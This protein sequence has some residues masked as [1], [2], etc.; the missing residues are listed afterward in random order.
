VGFEN[1]RRLITEDPLF[2]KSLRNTV[3]YTLMSVPFGL[4]TA[5]GLALLLNWEF[6]GRS[7]FRTLFF[8]PSVIPLVAASVLW[9]WLY[10]GEYGLINHMLG[11]VGIRGLNWM[12]DEH[13][14]KPAIVLM[15]IWT[16]GG[17]MIIC[18]AGLQGIP[19]HLQEA[20]QIDGANAWQRFI[21][22]TIPMLS[23][24]LFFLIIMGFIGSFQIFTQAY[25]MT[26]GSGAPQDATLFYV[27]YLYRQ[28]FTY[29]NMGYA[30]AMAWFLVIIIAIVSYLQFKFSSRWVYYGG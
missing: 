12:L 11:K 9:L 23:P 28:G 1:F 6:R 10:N 30:S 17:G 7:I 20:A 16:V 21:H 24:T 8:I 15:G 4:L 22:I 2:Y 25:V 13:L 26:D 5:L 27:F 29:F 14:A 3:I 18:L 19:R